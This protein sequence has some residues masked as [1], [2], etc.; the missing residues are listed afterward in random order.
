MLEL[1]NMRGLVPFLRSVIAFCLALGIGLVLVLLGWPLSDQFESIL[2]IAQRV[3]A[4]AF[5]ISYL[6]LVIFLNPVTKGRW[7]LI[8]LA[9]LILLV[10]SLERA[11]SAW[12]SHYSQIPLHSILV[13]IATLIQLGVVVSYVPRIIPWLEDHFIRK[14]NPGML[15]VSTFA[16]LV[17]IGA[18]L[19]KV[20][21]ATDSPITWLDAFFTSA[22]AVCVTGLTVVD[23]GQSFTFM[24]Q[25]IVLILI[26]IGGLGIM[27]LTF[28]MAVI[29]RQGMRLS[30]QIV[31]REL[32]SAENLHNLGTILI[33]VI[34]F[35]LVF[36]LVGAAGIYRI[37][38]VDWTGSENLIWVSVFHSISA[39]CNA[40][41]SIFS[42]G[43]ADPKVADNHMLQALLMGMIILGGL[44]YPV[45]N[46]IWRKLLQLFGLSV[47]T[48]ESGKWSLH[49]RLVLVFTTVL[50]VGGA[51]LMA[52]GSKHLA[53]APLSEL[54]WRSLFNSITARTAGFNISDIGGLSSASTAVMIG[55]MFIGGSPGGMAGGVKTTTVLVAVLNLNRILFRKRDLNVMKRRIADSACN[56]A[57]AVILLSQLWIVSATI[58]ILI[59]QPHFLFIDV[60]FETVSAFATVGLTRGITTELNAV[61]QI[62][63]IL[64]MLVGR[65]GI[66]SFFF[67]LLPQRDHFRATLP[68]GTINME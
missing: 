59:S 57:F 56:Q 47:R 63:I 36:E 12:L 28:F 6:V 42:D 60:L 18:A 5:A 22:S 58:L 53:D 4:L 9:V 61:S 23:T 20:P 2:L 46:E 68:T 55:L 1:G 39:L 64:T 62:V 13:V 17:V 40:G 7:L 38:A 14:M 31:L 51:F 16:C 35:T 30:S 33:S 11:I 50:I 32:F 44:G 29:A 34:G 25:G 24:G 3:S 26:Q 52:M 27:T 19:L 65:V 54:V 45:L 48:V 66:L 37:L 10:A 15:L 21:N 49:T 41:F 67:A 8:P 43:L